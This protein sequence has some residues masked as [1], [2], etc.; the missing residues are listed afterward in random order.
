MSILQ[1]RAGSTAPAVE[2]HDFQLRV[3][4][5]DAT[6]VIA[7]RGEVDIATV[8]PLRAALAEAA[9]A[10]QP[11]FVVDLTEV[12]FIDSVGVGAILHAKRRAGAEGRMAVVV[13]ESSYARVIFEVVGADQVLDVFKTRDEAF[14]AFAG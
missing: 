8:P 11:R 7:G 1:R 10:E 6:T 5:H 14:T 3:E 2:P 13:P 9:E 4:S 12:T